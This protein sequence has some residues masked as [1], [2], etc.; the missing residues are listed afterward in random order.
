MVDDSHQIRFVNMNVATILKHR[1]SLT[2]PG[3]ANN[4]L[5][6]YERITTLFNSIANYSC[7]ADLFIHEFKFKS[8]AFPSDRAVCNCFDH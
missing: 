4:T 7:S 8:G 3:V 5:K 6:L 1:D 2:E